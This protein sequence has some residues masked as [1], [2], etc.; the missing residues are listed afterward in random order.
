[1]AYFGRDIGGLPSK[2][3]TRGFANQSSGFPDNT[4]P[5]WWGKMIEAAVYHL[6]NELVDL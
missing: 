6:Q 1:M 2:S 3:G 4:A 5:D